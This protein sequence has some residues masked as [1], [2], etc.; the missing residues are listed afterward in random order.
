MTKPTKAF[1][2]PALLAAF[3]LTATPAAAAELP[4]IANEAP[5]QVSTAVSSYH[6][7]WGWGRHH[8]YR[9]RGR[10]SAGDV[11]GAVLVLGTIAAVANAASRANRDRDYRYPERYPYPDRR[12]EDRRWE[13]RRGYRADGPRGVEGAADACLRE[14]ER[15]GRVEDVARV[16]R[17]ASGWLVT[18]EMADGAGFSCSIGADGRIDRIEIGGRAAVLTETRDDE[19]DAD[20]AWRA[21]EAPAQSGVP[22]R[23]GEAS[24]ED[25]APLRDYPPAP[26]PEEEGAAAADYPGGPLPGDEEAD[27]E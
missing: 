23:D 9:H 5:S 4:T 15:D 25:D 13:D 18:G 22:R 3:S 24:S 21:S 27:P 8:R 2:L 26:T 17:N 11:I 12:W 1:A 7:G 14:I 19:S 16:E 10:T 20:T 6:G